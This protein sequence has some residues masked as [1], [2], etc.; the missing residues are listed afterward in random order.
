[1]IK[2]LQ[3]LQKVQYCIAY[4]NKGEKIELYTVRTNFVFGL[5]RRTRMNSLRK[6][7]RSSRPLSVYPESFDS[8]SRAQGRRLRFSM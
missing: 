2:W 4:Q 5:P 3:H 7:N 8:I 6:Q 1:M